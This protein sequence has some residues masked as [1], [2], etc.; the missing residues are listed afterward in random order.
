M[1]DISDDELDLDFS[2]LYPLIIS[3]EED[4][5]DD[6]KAHNDVSASMTMEESRLSI[7]QQLRTFL[8]HWYPK[9]FFRLREEFVNIS[10]YVMKKKNIHWLDCYVASEGDQKINF[11]HFWIDA[12]EDLGIWPTDSFIDWYRF[13]ERPLFEPIEEWETM[14][15]E[16]VRTNGNL[17]EYYKWMEES[18]N[19]VYELD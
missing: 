13:Y 3:H 19:S 15:T 12:A 14:Y 17:S 16:L 5:L 8:E 7:I 9:M 18:R 6:E 2:S 10:K 4:V 1:S 11:D